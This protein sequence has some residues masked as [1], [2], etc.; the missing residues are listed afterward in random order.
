MSVKQLAD[1][2]YTTI[3]HPHLEGVTVH[4]ND[5]FKLVTSKPPLLQ[6]W[7]EKGGLWTV[8]LAEEKAMNIYELPSMKEVVRFQHAALGFPTKATLLTSICNNNLITFP[9]MTSDNVVKF[10]PES[11]ETEKGH[12]K[13]TRQG[14]RS[15][16]VIDEDA[17]LEA[18]TLPKPTPGV[19]LKDVYLWLFDTTK[20]AMYSDQTGRFPITS[21]GG[22]K[23]TMVA[24]E[25]DGSYIDAEPIQPQNLPR[26]TNGFTP[27]GKPQEL[28]AQ[29]GTFSTTKHLKNF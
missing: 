11:N 3:F 10:F 18:E 20:K 16:K 4:D 15:T 7:R 22:H 8:A 9:G 27:D 1:Q 25:L 21:A 29:I 5:G 2:G 23:Y 12:M 17:M 6:G 28:Y 14:V 13:Q 26:H 19:K 24:V